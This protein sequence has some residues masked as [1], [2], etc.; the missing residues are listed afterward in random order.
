MQSLEASSKQ[1]K[2]FFKKYGTEQVY[3]D[4]IAFELKITDKK[5]NPVQS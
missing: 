3:R 2:K 4:E 5:G 1:V